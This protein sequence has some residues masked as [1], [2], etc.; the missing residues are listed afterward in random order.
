MA[1]AYITCLVGS[2]VSG[3][4]EAANGLSVAARFAN[5]VCGYALLLLNLH[6]ARRHF[7][8][9]WARHFLP[10]VTVRNLCQLLVQQMALCT[11]LPKDACVQPSCM[12]EKLCE[13]QYSQIKA[14]FRGSPCIRDMVMGTQLLHL[15]NLRGHSAPAPSESQEALSKEEAKK[16]ATRCWRSCFLFQSWICQ[17]LPLIWGFRGFRPEP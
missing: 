8:A 5:A 4:T 7:G 10:V 2:L 9:D 1:G 12:Q 14:P 3:C 13:Y 15:K 17:G 11:I 6:A 16:V